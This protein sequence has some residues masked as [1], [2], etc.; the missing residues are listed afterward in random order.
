MDHMKTALALAAAVLA[1]LAACACDDRGASDSGCDPR[2]DYAGNETVCCESYGI[3]SDGGYCCY[4]FEWTLGS[5]CVG[6]G[7]TDAGG[8]T[9]G[10]GKQVVVDSCC[11]DR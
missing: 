7:E 2:E 6:G 8:D 11:E 4:D 9:N 5:E 1:A 10:G 3:G